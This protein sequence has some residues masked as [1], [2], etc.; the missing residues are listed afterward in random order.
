[1]SISKRLFTFSMV[2]FLLGAAAAAQEPDVPPPVAVTLTAE[3]ARILE[4]IRANDWRAI[5]DAFSTRLR[6]RSGVTYREEQL[7]D[8]RG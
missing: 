3:Q 8:K 5:R 4:G 2:V 7:E 1:M 6:S